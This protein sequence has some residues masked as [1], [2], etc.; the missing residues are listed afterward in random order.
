[1]APALWINVVTAWLRAISAA[2]C[3][4]ASVSVRSTLT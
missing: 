4:V 1:M 3:R 2:A